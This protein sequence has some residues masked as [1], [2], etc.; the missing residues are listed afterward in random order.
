MS[1]AWQT[2]RVASATTAGASADLAAAR[3]AARRRL[4]Q[5]RLL[6][7]VGSVLIAYGLSGVVVLAT[8]AQAIGAPLDEAD[9]LTVSIE[10]QR[11][12]V[13]QSL[14]SAEETI[15]QT[16]AGIRNMDASLEQARA[17]TDRASQLSLSMATTMYQLRDQMAITVFGIQPL[18]GLAPGFDQTGQQMELLSSDVAAIGEALNANRQDVETVA[19][20]MERLKRSV[21]R[22][23]DAISE[24][25]RLEATSEGI[26]NVR[27]GIF[28]VAAWLITLAVGCVLGGLGCWWLARRA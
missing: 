6:R 4:R 18:V 16:T 14:S 21:Q 19:A 22:L 27:L 23:A 2:P 13:L 9:E 20:S 15:D 3:V 5:R 12:A 8:V 11:R 10:G 1:T 25:P 26:A 7:L 17:A 24:G 28:A